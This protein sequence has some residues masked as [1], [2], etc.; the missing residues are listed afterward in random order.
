M[1]FLCS[2][3]DPTIERLGEVAPTELHSVVINGVNPTTGYNYHLFFGAEDESRLPQIGISTEPRRSFLE[4][5]SE[6]EAEDALL[7][8]GNQVRK[9]SGGIF[10]VGRLATGI[11]G[12]TSPVRKTACEK[13]PYKGLGVTIFLSDDGYYSPDKVSPIRALARSS[14]VSDLPFVNVPVYDAD[15]S[16]KNPNQTERDAAVRDGF[17][18][19]WDTEFRRMNGPERRFFRPTVPVAME[20]TPVNVTALL[21]NLGNRALFD[22]VTIDALLVNR[23]G[24]ISPAGTSLLGLVLLS[25]AEPTLRS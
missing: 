3:K 25:E 24:T 10:R 15:S 13:D 22:D 18:D 4:R 9:R 7:E 16:R 6:A 14:S 21:Q 8:F 17:G 12:A 20:V 23:R 5:G 1:H 2:V 11:R 19:L